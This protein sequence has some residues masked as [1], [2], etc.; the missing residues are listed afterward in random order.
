MLSV[1][2][3]SA[4]LIQ[5]LL[6]ALRQSYEQNQ[7]LNGIIRNMQA[8]HEASYLQTTETEKQTAQMTLARFRSNTAEVDKI[9]RNLTDQ[10]QGMENDMRE[11]KQICCHPLGLIQETNAPIKENVGRS[12][13]YRRCK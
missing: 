6:F 11:G 7:A 8:H 13:A 5:R 2:N 12:R 1:L 3:Y 4:D 10:T 9:L